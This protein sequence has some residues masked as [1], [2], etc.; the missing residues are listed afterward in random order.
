[1]KG[2]IHVLHN[3]RKGTDD[4]LFEVRSVL[5]VHDS[6]SDRKLN[7][8]NPNESGPMKVDFPSQ[9]SVISICR[10]SL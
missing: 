1:M 8:S 5:G 3:L 4:V 9:I 10:R 2:D 7:T 6:V